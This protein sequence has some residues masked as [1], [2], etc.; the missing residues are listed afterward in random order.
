MKLGVS[1]AVVFPAVILPYYQIFLRSDLFP[2][3]R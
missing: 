3:R 2:P 1:G